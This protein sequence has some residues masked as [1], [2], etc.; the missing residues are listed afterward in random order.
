M[1]AGPFRAAPALRALDGIFL[2]SCGLLFASGLAGIALLHQPVITRDL[3]GI[4]S[5]FLR[6][7]SLGMQILRT[8]V[9]HIL[10]F[11]RLLAWLDVHWLGAQQWAALAAIP[12]ACLA[13]AALVA[14]GARRSGAGPWLAA[15]AAAAGLLWMGNGF[16][17]TWAMQ[18][19]FFMAPAFALAAVTVLTAPAG[20][21]AGRL[22]LCLLLALG[23][24]LASGS[25]LVGC[26]A[27]ALVAP[28]LRL[29]ARRLGALLAGLAAILAGVLWLR[30]LTHRADLNPVWPWLQDPWPVLLYMQNYLRA[31]AE[32]ALRVL[33]PNYQSVLWSGIV[34][35]LGLLWIAVVWVI[36]LRSGRRPS[37]LATQALLLCLLAFGSALVTALVRLDGG[38]QQAYS[39]RYLTTS[40]LYWIGLALLALDAAS[41]ARRLA[42]G[43]ILLALLLVNLLLLADLPRHWRIWSGHHAELLQSAGAVLAD[44]ADDEPWLRIHPNLTL[45]R[46]TFGRLRALQGG[47]FA[48]PEAAW[49]G[50][51]AGALFPPGESCDVTTRWLAPRVTAQ[52]NWALAGW[53][54][55]GAGDAPDVVLLVDAQGLIAGLT[56][57]DP[58]V[59][60]AERPPGAPAQGWE[61]WPTAAQRRA[62]HLL[63]VAGGTSCPLPWP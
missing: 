2:L 39:Q 6:G 51:P 11:Q 46:D 49:I 21:G 53:S 45:A 40:L 62:G 20:P 31:P 12:L 34:A 61:L 19:H 30:G 56:W 4:E 27:L 37:P 44:S 33:L 24:A 28:A 5:S 35:D 7:D 52:G 59:R 48:W 63:A 57:P 18:A 29:P 55:D 14:R 42:R 32:M 47:P 22:A 9:D 16:N 43:A 36:A 10:A 13:I 3:V 8:H 41:R 23:A 15:G 60:S 1:T 58:G 25:G 38:P 50:Q 26:V 17:L 54:S